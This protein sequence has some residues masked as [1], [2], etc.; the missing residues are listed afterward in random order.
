VVIHRFHEQTGYLVFC[1]GDTSLRMSEQQMASLRILRAC[2]RATMR[3]CL[4]SWFS[5]HIP[6]ALKGSVHGL[7]K[8]SSVTETIQGR[9]K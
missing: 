4:K 8:G 6:D 2:V 7:L 9:A 1:S 3:C 5:R